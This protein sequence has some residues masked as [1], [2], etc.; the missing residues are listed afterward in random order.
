MFGRSRVKYSF[1][2]EKKDFRFYRSPIDSTRKIGLAPMM[3]SAASR[4]SKAPSLASMPPL[5]SPGPND[6]FVE[7]LNQVLDRQTDRQ[8]EL[9][10][11]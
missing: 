8:T 1:S 11:E 10:E 3:S 7:M 4:H 5:A 2:G 6:V 9:T